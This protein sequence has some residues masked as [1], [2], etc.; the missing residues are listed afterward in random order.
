MT[1]YDLYVIDW[2]TLDIDTDI[3][4]SDSEEEV[5]YRQCSK[6]LVVRSFC[7][8][9]DGKTYVLDIRGYLPYYYIKIPESWTRTKLSI[10]TEGLKSHV[11]KYFHNT[12]ASI[13]IIKAKPFYGFT[14]TDKFKYAKLTFTCISGFWAFS[15]P[16]KNSLKIH[17]LFQGRPHL[18]QLYESNLPPLLRF[19]HD[20]NL[21]S[22]GW[23]RVSRC[24]K[25]YN[26]TTCDFKLLCSH[27][28][29]S[30]TEKEG[31]PP[32][33]Y[34]GFDI[35]ADSSHG[36]FPIAK[37]TYIKLARELITEYVDTLYENKD[38]NM[39]EFLARMLKY[40]FNPYYNNYNIKNLKLIK[41]EPYV[42][43]TIENYCERITSLLDDD[44]IDGII[45]ILETEFPA[46]DTNFCDYFSMAEQM[47]IEYKKQRAQNGREIKSNPQAVV[48][49]ML[50]LAF[51]EYY[52]NPD[53]NKIYTKGGKRPSTDTLKNIVPS[54]NSICEKAYKV[55]LHE[56]RCKKMRAAKVKAS[57]I[58]KLP[59]STNMC[60]NELDEL[61]NTYFPAVEDDPVI[62]IGT[63]FKKYGDT[64]CYLKHIICLNTCNKIDN[65]KLIDYEYDGLMISDEEKNIK[66]EKQYLTDK[67]KVV[68]ECYDTE[69]EVLLAWTRLIQTENPDIVSGYNIFGFDFK[70]LYDRASQLGILSDFMK[71]GKIKNVEEVLI[72]K[73]LASAGLGENLLHLISM[74]GRVTM[75]IYKVMQS[76][77]RLDSY[78]LNSI[79]EKFLKKKKVDVSPQEIFIK[80]RGTTEER[81][82]VAEY[83]L[84]D[85]ILCNRL[86]DKFELILNNIGM[87]QVCSIPLGFLFLR[88]QGIKLFSYVAK[89]CGKKGHLIQVM[90]EDTDTSKYEGAIVL[91]PQMDIHEDEP[92]FVADFNSL[93]PSCIISENLSHNSFIGYKVVGK[94]ESTDVRGQCITES[95]YEK[96][97]LAGEYPGWDYVDIVYDV[98]KDVPVRPGSKTV[99]KIVVGHKICRFSQPANGEK[100]IIPTI[101]IDLLAA[102]KNAKKKRDTFQKGSFQYNLYEGL[103]LAY[104]V[105]ANSLYGIMGAKAS[106]IRMREIAACTT[107]TGRKLIEYSS[108]YVLDNYPGSSIVYGDT[109]SIFCK[110]PCYNRK[111][112][113]LTGLD[114]INK[115]ILL[116]TE[117]SYYIS[118]TLK[119]PHNLEFEK[120]IYPF[121]L[122]SKKRYHGHYY[123]EYGSP[124]YYANSMGIVLKRRDNAKIVKHVFGGMIDIIMKDHSV[125]KAIKFVEEECQ[126][127]LD[128]KFP[129]EMF[130]ISKTLKSYYALPDSI[131]H[132]VLAQRIGKRDPGN[133]P[134][135]NDRVTY[136]YIVNKDATLQG[137]RIETPEFI[138]EHNLKLD[139]GHYI[140]NQ[141][142]KP[143]TEILKL[144]KKD[145]GL[146]ERLID[147]Y[148]AKQAGVRRLDSF[149]GFFTIRPRKVKKEI[150]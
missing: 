66:K 65:K 29:V 142:Q 123:T 143:V 17:G 50:E 57:D 78:S 92:T 72:E 102:R 76:M 3:D 86:I 144:A 110:F 100:D 133:K 130:L 42:K 95:I 146:F 32:I 139:Y 82:E 6:E 87:A 19:I 67:A 35:E 107:A 25:I 111:G 23:M 122:F 115:G 101:L 64:D 145:K 148:K 30:P 15:K 108:K 80:Q 4:E 119:K 37:K 48:S 31:I 41:D 124:S 140:T 104:K 51:D 47:S 27:T 109:D 18:Y 24:K 69:E 7:M 93:Y 103:Q 79:S 60:I 12:L 118:E 75:D 81:T 39:R 14:A 16:L 98:Y 117:A 94:G 33:K 89:I 90:E 68:V 34:V 106:Q 71:M 28:D 129:L 116:C 22:V 74:K 1:D 141:I 85:C 127:V 45:Y 46:I 11:K 114:A 8:A 84:I 43:E 149:A 88:G 97:L 150:K 121:I 96:N 20:R 55:F 132:N 21:K 134:R 52:N 136:A 58:P 120:A 138:R 126:K 40:A 131:A 36:D 5:K 128:G 105:T 83:C 49:V 70:Y 113:K 99:N 147:T 59:Y 38:M 44:D 61:F 53:I 137:E 2:D 13:E 112:E 10:F 56:K 73:K 125:D 9:Q 26:D 54:I 91:D 135:S 77:H 62:Q 63:T